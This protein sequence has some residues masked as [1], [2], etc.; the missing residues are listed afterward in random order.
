MCCSTKHIFQVR[1]RL[2]VAVERIN[3]LEE[4]L[5][6]SNQE[7]WG[8]SCFLSKW[9]RLVK[10]YKM[11][12]WTVNYHMHISIYLWKPEGPS[13]DLKLYKRAHRWWLPHKLTYLITLLLFFSIYF[14]TFWS[15]DFLLRSPK[16]ITTRLCYRQLSNI[17]V[18]YYFSWASSKR[19]GMEWKD[20]PSSS[21]H[22]TNQTQLREMIL[23]LTRFVDLE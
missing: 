16:I 22:S 12:W 5:S 10:Q 13:P 20:Q 1:E 18:V 7:V 23:T 11:Q 6:V 3:Q 8:F 14:F 4:D 15:Q 9:L 2:K 17:S 19:V 21:Q